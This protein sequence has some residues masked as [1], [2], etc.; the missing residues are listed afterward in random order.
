MRKH[1]LAVLWVCGLYW[2]WEV[3]VK[4]LLRCLL[5]AGREEAEHSEMA[6]ET[7]RQKRLTMV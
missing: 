1:R 7:S 5:R 6:D 2:E 4:R 3:E